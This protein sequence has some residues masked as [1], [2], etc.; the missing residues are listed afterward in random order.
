MTFC[1]LPSVLS[2]ESTL[3]SCVGVLVSFSLLSG[4]P[5]GSECSVFF[6]PDVLFFSLL[7]PFPAY[8]SA[9][10]PCLLF[11]V[12]F[13]VSCIDHVKRYLLVVVAYIL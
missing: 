12:S 4:S 3:G 11:S 13:V 10:S 8:D 5:D 7:S 1:G 2:G 9:S 6:S